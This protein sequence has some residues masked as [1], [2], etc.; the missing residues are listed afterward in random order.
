[1][2][3]APAP[4]TRAAPRRAPAAHGAASYRALT[5][6]LDARE[7]REEDHPDL[8]SFQDAWREWDAEYEPFEEARTF[9]AV[10][11]CEHGCGFSTLLVVSGPH[12]GTMWFDRRATSDTI[13]PVHRR[14]GGIAGFAEWYLDRLAGFENASGRG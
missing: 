3:G 13:D 7:P 1:M 2:R 11:L 10:H 8:G 4:R 14:D 6:E 5:E 9:G 12:R